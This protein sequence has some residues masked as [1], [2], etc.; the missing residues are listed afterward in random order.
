[1]NRSVYPRVGYYQVIEWG[2]GGDLRE[3]IVGKKG[4]CSCGGR[5]QK[6]ARCDHVKVVLEHLEKGGAK[7]PSKPVRKPHAVK[8]PGKCPICDGDI[9]LDKPHR[10]REWF[11][12]CENSIAHYWMWR[13]GNAVKAFLTDRGHPNKLGP[14]YKKPFIAGG[15]ICLALTLLALLRP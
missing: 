12:A 8:L 15:V 14:F 5:W 7:A 4:R 6:D 3:F 13:G 11:W 1:M 9:T 2:E 10:A